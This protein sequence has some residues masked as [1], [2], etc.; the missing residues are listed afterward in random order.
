MLTAQRPKILVVDDNPRNAA[1]I[2]GYIKPHYDVV[3]AG[4]GEEC[5][6]LLEKEDIAL[7]ILD[8]ILP[9]INGYEV[10]QKIK[11]NKATK[12]IPVMLIPALPTGQEKI[13]SIQAGAEDFISRPF[14]M[15]EVVA[16]VRALLKIKG[17]YTDLEKTNENLASI[18]S[19]TSGI[20]KDFDPMT[21]NSKEFY[22]SLLGMI[23]RKKPYEREKPVHVFMGKTDGGKIKGKVFS[24]GA[25]PAECIIPE[26]FYAR[27]DEA[28][29]NDACGVIFS[30]HTDEESALKYQEHFHHAITEVVGM[31]V[32]FVAYISR[33]AVI[34]AFNYGR[35]VTLSDAQALKGLSIHIPFFKSIS[36]RMKETEDGFS[37]AINALSKAAEVNDDN[38]GNHILRLNKYS[39]A[40]A[41]KLGLPEKFVHDIGLAAQMHDVGKIQVH[42][43]ILKKPGQLS[44][45]EFE[46]I[47]QHPLYGARILGEHPRL[48]MAQAIALTHH[49][50]WDGSG[51]PY[52]LKGDIIPIEGRILNIADQYDAL[53]S[54]RPYKPAYG[55]E[56]TCRILTEGDGKTLPYHFDPQV[57]QA[58]KDLANQLEGIYEGLH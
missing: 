56:K 24:N 53:R 35:A 58:F 37:Y 38:T 29:N 2:E 52:G 4:S 5:L 27:K 36:G 42:P 28:K 16:R 33:H 34:I 40:I 17:L 39:M 55:H 9:G 20:L 30:N 50:C 13:R 32:N 8:I 15:N 18:I 21:F 7:V 3:K 46:T 41:K 12:K 49:E 57:L 10:C 43:D 1:L 31:V 26:N 11:A 54:I 45:A 25:E 22:K 19:Y 6:L 44:S 51:Y 48:K 23:L 14:S 47:K